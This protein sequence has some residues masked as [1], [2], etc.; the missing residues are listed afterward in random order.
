MNTEQ[1]SNEFDVLLNTSSVIKP[2]GFTQGIEL[3][4]YEKSVF[5]SHAQEELIRKTYRGQNFMRESFEET[6]LMR[7]YIDRLIKQQTVTTKVNIPS[8]ES[9]SERSTFF[10]LPTDVMVITLEQLELISDDIC[11]NGKKINILPVRQDE[12]TMQKGNPFRRPT[13]KGR[14]NTAWRLDYGNNSERIVEIIPPENS[15]ADKY[16]VRYIRKPKPIILTPIS[17]LDIDGVSTVTESEID[18]IFH[19]Q[20][21]ELAVQKALQSKSLTA[22]QQTEE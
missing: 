13:L 22:R 2:Y 15:Q 6:E 1:F 9:L 5:L 10:E 8:T 21:L 7:R 17:P 3:D 11:F 18:S 20:I 14:T 4:E 19:R 12:Y 16:V